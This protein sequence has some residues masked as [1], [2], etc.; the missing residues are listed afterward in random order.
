M[1]EIPTPTPTPT[2]RVWWI[3]NIPNEP[4]YFL[5]SSIEEACQM[6]NSLAEI[7]LKNPRI[8]SNVG[9]LMGREDIKP[10]FLPTEWDSD[11]FD[12]DGSLWLEWHDEEGN[13]IEYYLRRQTNDW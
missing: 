13:D 2:L 5:V 12:E 6:L 7:D 11:W 1:S 8:E 3:R 4:E 9:G 10:G